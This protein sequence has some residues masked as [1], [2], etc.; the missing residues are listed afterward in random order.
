MANALLELPHEV[1]HS[2]LV[3]VAP[4]DLAALSCCHALDDYMKHDRLLFKEIYRRHFDAIADNTFIDWKAELR[5][6]V[7]FEKTLTSGSY[8]L[9]LEDLLQIGGCVQ[10]L[11]K[12]ASTGGCSSNI[13]F[14]DR[15]VRDSNN[16]GILCNSSLFEWA[17]A[18]TST[19]TQSHLR[20]SDDTS[21]ADDSDSDI[22][23][24]RPFSPDESTREDKDSE[25]GSGIVRKVIHVPHA[26]RLQDQIH[27]LSAKLHCLYGVPV[28]RTRITEP[29]RSSHQRRLCSGVNVKLHPFARSRVY[30]LRQHSESTLWGPFA[31][32]GSQNV[33]WEKLEAIMM[34]LDYNIR[35]FT[36]KY[37]A[38]GSNLIPPWDRPFVGV[39]PHSLNLN[40]NPLE[41]SIER[42]PPLPIDLQDP[43]GASGTWMR[44][45]C[46][47][48]YRE[49]FTFNFSE[50]QPPPGQHRPPLDTE[51]AIRFIVVKLQVTKI[52]KPGEKD[53]QGLP[54]V[55]FEGNSSS[56]LPPVDANATSK[57]RGTVR[58]TPEGEVR[59]TTFSV[60]HGEER[61][62]SEG[63]QLGGVQA[64]RGVLGYWFDKDFDE[65]GP[66]GPTAFWKVSS[67]TEYDAVNDL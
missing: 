50:D 62:R 65:Y 25:L 46:F 33:D 60:F 19:A 39:T 28:Q 18:T 34:I 4:T 29:D 7:R 10:R 66:A 56:A 47:L 59:W 44:V 40:Q 36:N 41:A 67:D 1:L 54:V 52:E 64:A 9:K 14:L 53:G 61:W 12:T 43:Y 15:L 42:P 8:K 57:I 38:H 35:N 37:V 11:I 32:D 2:I 26:T 6:L 27:R 24:P 63:I 30:D 16:V 22:G 3:H 31:E 51:E 20:H 21:S 13:A 58:L 17:T 49:L 55:H 48:D 23:C 5:D 45:V